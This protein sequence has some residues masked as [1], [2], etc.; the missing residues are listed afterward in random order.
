[1]NAVDQNGDGTLDWK[2]A[3]ILAETVSNNTTNMINGAKEMAVNMQRQALRPIFA[4]DLDSDVFPKIK[5][6]R[7][8]KRDKRREENAVCK[9]SIGY[10]SNQKSLEVINVYR[11][12]VDAFKF[13]FYPDADSEI[14]YV[15]PSDWH[16]YIAL[17]DYFSFLKEARINELQRIAQELGAKHFSVTFK[18]QKTSFVSRNVKAKAQT[19]LGGEQS[20]GDAEY[21]LSSTAV[22]IDEIA[23]Q[24]DC[25]GHAP[26]KCPE[27]FYLSGEQGIHTLIKLRMNE[28]SPISHQKYTLNLSTSSG[29]KEKD[30]VEIDA[31]LKSMKFSGDVTVAS[32]AKKEARRFFE[33]EIDF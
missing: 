4:E 29:I 5:L 7:I 28:V 2:D 20:S 9:G 23:A 33:Y 22:D 11:D 1:V 24:M 27:L 6:L 15:D 10:F 18:E 31:A 26:T 32:E 14:Y 19:H 16:K 13:T 17:D 3:A 25:P 30:A 8:I 21:D 12:S